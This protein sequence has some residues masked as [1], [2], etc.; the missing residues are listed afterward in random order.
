MPLGSAIRPLFTEPV[1]YHLPHGQYR[2]SGYVIIL[3]QDF[4]TFANSLP[5][6]PSDL[7][8][9]IVRKEGINQSHCNFHVRRSVVL[10]A[11][12]WLLQNNTYYHNINIDYDAL[13]LLPENGN[14]T[15]LSSVLI[16]SEVNQTEVSLAQDQDVC[17]AYL[18]RTFVPV[19][20]R[21]MTEQKTFRWAVQDRQSHQ[22][23]AFAWPSCGNSVNEFNISPH[24]FQ[25]VLL[26]FWHLVNV[27]SLL[28]TFLSIS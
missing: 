22:S 17:D 26:I 1:T 16:K 5:R 20:A 25:Q 6:M 13:L 10:H 11:L 4:T 21:K 27:Q 24:C 3:P 23:P 12:R 28:N 9:I 19:T 15:D 14:L 7:D 2:Y 8:I 18:S